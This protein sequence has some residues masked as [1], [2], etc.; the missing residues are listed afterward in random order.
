MK[1]LKDVETRSGGQEKTIIFSQV[2]V[3]QNIWRHIHEIYRRCSLSSPRIWKF[4]KVSCEKRESAL[5]V[6]SQRTFVIG[7]PHRDLNALIFSLDTGKMN[8]K[9]RDAALE[10]IK[11]DT[12]I[13][14]ILISIKCG[15]TGLNL[16]SCNNV[17]LM[18]LWW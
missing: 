9:K 17:I 13:K 6:V 16:V 8:K 2:S 11:T 12:T 5:S 10:A 14:V 1:L 7:S 18:D 4:W 3:V 15:S